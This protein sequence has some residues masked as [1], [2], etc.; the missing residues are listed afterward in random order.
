MSAFIWSCVQPLS[1]VGNLE[2][3]PDHYSIHCW[4]THE[5]IAKFNPNPWTAFS[6]MLVIQTYKCVHTKHV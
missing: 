1:S 3:D 2:N 4:V 5:P 6:V